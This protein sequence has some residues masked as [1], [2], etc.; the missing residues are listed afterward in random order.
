MTDRNSMDDSPRNP[1]LRG[2]GT[3]VDISAEMALFARN[4]ADIAGVLGKTERQRH[5]TKEADDLSAVINEKMW[6]DKSRFYFDLNLEEEQCDI[7]TVAGFWPLIAQAASPAQAKHLAEHLQNPKTF[8][9]LYPVPSLSADAKEYVSHGGYW[10]GA[11]WPPTNTMVVLGLEKYGFDSLAYI[12]A[13]K[14]LE[15][16]VGVYSHTGTIWENYAT[17]FLSQGFFVNGQPVKKNF[18]GWSG[19]GPIKFLLEYGVGLKADA[20]NNK[21]VWTIRSLDD[22][23]CNRFTF[24]KAG[25]HLLAKKAQNGIREIHVE[26]DKDFL[27]E[28][29]YNGEKY[30]FPVR[31]GKQTFS[32]PEKGSKQIAAV[33]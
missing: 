13:K 33:R 29:K 8:G 10:R 5:Y 25:I 3:A 20:V 14:H 21:I 19:I 15:Q 32:L 31:T 7:K 18:V 1:W 28:V 30:S 4:L 27:L 23:G 6:N 16:V 12:I 17:D 9:R 11:V 2:G 26:S 24:N 22:V